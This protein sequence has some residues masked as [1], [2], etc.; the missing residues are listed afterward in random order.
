MKT[1]DILKETMSEINLTPG[2][3]DIGGQKI[4]GILGSDRIDNKGRFANYDTNYLIFN[5]LVK[6]LASM[7]DVEINDLFV[8]NILNSAS[9]DIKPSGFYIDRKH[10]KY[11]VYSV[12]SILY[13]IC[14]K[15]EDKSLKVL[16]NKYV[17]N[18]EYSKY[19]QEKPVSN[20][21]NTKSS[22]EQKYNDN[23]E[24]RSWYDPSEKED[25]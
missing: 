8:K 3:Y 24:I 23:L 19:I 18:G 20:K 25:E 14:A 11:P 1:L 17:L 4:K 13:K 9:A 22:D 5:N 21:K 10:R 12:K 2:I 16:G 6:V 7:L 15:N